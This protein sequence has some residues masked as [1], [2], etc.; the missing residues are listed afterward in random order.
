MYPASFDYFQAENVEQASR[1]LR[2]Y[3]EEARVIAGG[4]SLIP[5][6]KYRL[7]LPKYLVDIR[8]IPGLSFIDKKDGC[9]RIGALTVHREIEESDLIRSQ[10]P[11]M[12]D[13]APLIGDP[14][15]RNLGTLGGALCHADPAG[16]WGP[17]VLA[18]EGRLKCVGANGER[19]LEAKDFFV[20][21]YSTRLQPDEVLTE[22]VLPVPGA[23]SGGAYL[24]LA[25]RTGD[26]AMASVA[27]QL[28][29]DEAGVCQHIG[30]GAGAAG[31]TPLRVPDAEGVV[32]GEKI[33]ATVLKKAARR[34]S[35][36]AD[37]IPDLRGS[38]EYKR[39]ILKA[40]LQRAAQIAAS[41]CKE[42]R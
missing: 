7:A 22:V 6:M 14:Q 4:Q 37:P 32:R 12:R 21:A 39:E 35:Q 3:G 5:F 24:K 18:L 20:D 25:R 31:R 40:L 42:R 36:A 13:A 1:L 2:E 23:K 38:G 15:V 41:R 19:E 8:G 11:I 28:T 33:S 26:F 27:V 9:V 17:V 29:L 34:L 10:L 30:I 16:D